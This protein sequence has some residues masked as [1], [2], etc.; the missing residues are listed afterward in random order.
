M[1]APNG[2][3]RA[4]RHPGPTPVGITSRI[5]WANRSRSS[6]WIACAVTCDTN[7]D[8]DLTLTVVADLLYRCLAERLKEGSVRASPHTV[9]RKFV[10]TP[11]SVKITADEIVVRLSKRAQNNPLL[12]EAC[13]D[14]SYQGGAVAGGSLCASGVSMTIA[15][16][17]P[18]AATAGVPP[19]AIAGQVGGRAFR[20]VRGTAKIGVETCYPRMGPQCFP[21]APGLRVGRGLK[22]GQERRWAVPR[23]V[24]PG[25]R[26]GRGL[27]QAPCQLDIKAQPCGARPSGRARIETSSRTR[28]PSPRKSVRMAFRVGREDWKHADYDNRVAGTRK[29]W[30]PAF[31]SGE[32]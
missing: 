18:P 15:T 16:P 12:Q 20:K 22:R 28:L 21:V 32:D 11:G 26:V 23:R 6:I 19:V 5:G 4:G 24:A 17:R 31:G 29:V 7:V 2:R 25:L 30:R 27:K 14:P 10:D 13:L 8:F 3:R 9:F 1:T